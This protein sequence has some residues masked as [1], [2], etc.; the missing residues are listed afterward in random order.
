MAVSNDSNRN[1]IGFRAYE[2]A[3]RQ[4]P[5]FGYFRLNTRLSFMQKG[6]DEPT[7]QI[8]YWFLVGNKGIEICEY[9]PKHEDKY[10]S[11]YVGIIFP[12]SPLTSR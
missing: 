7:T 1:G 4:V 10:I 6:F 3:E 5:G 2:P 8:T 11:I 12:Y 9:K